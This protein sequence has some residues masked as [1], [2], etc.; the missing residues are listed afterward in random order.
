MRILI[1]GGTG[2]IGH[3]FIQAYPDHEYT[4]LTRSPEKAKAKLPSRVVLIDCLSKL[5]NL[6]LFDSVINLAGE[7]IIDKRWTDQQ[8]KAICDSR[9]DVTQQLVDLFRVSKKPP[10]VFISGSAIGIY[11][12]Q[13]DLVVTERD[14]SA[15]LDFAA[16]LCQRWES[17]AKQAE[18]YTR[19]VNI[20][21]GIVLDPK[22][23]ALA[24]MLTPFKLC[25]GGRLGHG[26]QYMSWIH[27]QDMVAAIAFLI[28]SKDS[29]GAFN[30]VAP[31]PVT[32]Q[33]FTDELATA[34]NRIAFIPVP[35]AMLKLLLGESSV[36]LLASQR[37]EPVSLLDASFEYRFP[38]LTSALTD[39]LKHKPN[40]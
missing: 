31:T 20:R 18:P 38:D 26:R 1:T 16:T 28:N 2:F 3:R 11:G 22:A 13:G 14:T 40:A 15:P 33:Q 25:L 27:I 37:V 6:D 29:A 7:P 19:V 12:D 36:L 24:K 30:M 8:K 34:L 32:N 21:T 39:L 35:S 10:S 17:I 4:V 23:G 5:D 9:W